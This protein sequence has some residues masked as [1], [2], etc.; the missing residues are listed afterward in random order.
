MSSDDDQL[1]TSFDDYDQL[2]IFNSIYHENN[3]FSLK[4]LSEIV[5]FLL[6]NIV[7]FSDN[8]WYI[9]Q[10]HG[11]IKSPDILAYFPFDIILNY[12]ESLLTSDDQKFLNYITNII[13]SL[14]IKSHQKKVISY[15]KNNFIPNLRKSNFEKKL[16]PQSL[17]GFNNCIYDNLTFSFRNGTP[18]DYVSLSSNY[19]IPFT[20]ENHPH[21]I[22]LINL[23]KFIIPDP[24]D[25]DFFIMLCAFFFDGSGNSDEQFYFWIGNHHLKLP[26][27]QFIQLL[28]G[29][30]FSSVPCN[31]EIESANE[32]FQ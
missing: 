31:Q 19:E 30:Y 24:N 6:K 14:N 29:S 26:L 10:H 18:Q 9:F 28:L 12:A 23:L 27:L 16:N 5:C 2:K 32:L 7:V 20:S 3:K 8:N 22:A 25:F 1:S 15:C 17:F 13:H 11:W 4:S 21:H